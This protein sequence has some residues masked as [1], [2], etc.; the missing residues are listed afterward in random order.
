MFGHVGVQHRGNI[1]LGVAG[2]EQHAR[3][4][5][6]AGHPNGAQPVQPVAQDRAGEFEIAVLHRRVMQLVAQPMRHGGEFVHGILVAAAVAAD[7][8]AQLLRHA[9]LLH[10]YTATSKVARPTDAGRRDGADRDMENNMPL[11][12]RYTPPGFRR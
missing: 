10:L 4:G 7:H 2:R 3:H 1:V 11:L 6:Y 9:E 8:D 5:Q 12:H